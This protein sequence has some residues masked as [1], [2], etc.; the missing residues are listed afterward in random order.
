MTASELRRMADQVERQE[1]EATLSGVCEVVGIGVRE[2]QGRS[3]TA[4]TVKRRAVVA[5]ILTVRLGW[6]LA[7]AAE[8]LRRTERQ[9]I[10][11]VAA[12]K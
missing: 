12:E 6:S 10:R 2:L 11:L 8:A 9:V 4:D 7:R 5:W 1:A 3:R